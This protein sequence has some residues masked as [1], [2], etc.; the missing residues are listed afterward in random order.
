MSNIVYYVCDGGCFMDFVQ[1]LAGV[2]DQDFVSILRIVR[3]VINIISFAIPIILIILT[4][5]DIA[6]IVTAGNLD[7]KLKKEVTS[8]VVTRLIYAIVLLLIPTIVGLIFRF[9][10]VE[11]S[12]INGI[13][14]GDCWE[15]AK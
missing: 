10:P 8:K 1:I 13:T 6:K 4:I 2:C 14:W 9:I 7:D 12:T 3:W 11:Q 15:Q 5:L